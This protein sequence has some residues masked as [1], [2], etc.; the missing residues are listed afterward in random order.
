MKLKRILAGVLTAAMVLTSAPVAGLCSL[1]VQA[2]KEVTYEEVSR[3]ILEKNAFANSEQN[4]VGYTNDGPASY[5]FNGNS[6]NWWHSRYQSWNSLGDNE[7]VRSEEEKETVFVEGGKTVYVGS[8]FDEEILLGKITY[9][10]R[11]DNTNNWIGDFNL[12][13][14]DLSDP[15]ASPAEEDWRIVASS[16]A[17]EGRE[18]KTKFSAGSVQTVAL[19]TPV[20]ATHFRL[21]ALG[22]SDENKGDIHCVAATQICVFKAIAEEDTRTP[23]A[24]PDL[25]VTAPVE[26]AAPADVTV[27]SQEPGFTAVTAWTDAEGSAAAGSFEGGKT[28]TV[29][30]VLTADE[31][32]KFTADSIPSEITVDGEKAALSVENVTLSEDGTTM[33]IVCTLQAKEVGTEVPEALQEA[34]AKAAAIEENGKTYSAASKK[35]L[36]EA[37]AAAKAL[38]A[39]A[40]AEEL[41]SA[42]DAVLAAIENLAESWIAEEVYDGT[43]AI[44]ADSEEMT[45]ETPPNGPIGNAADG[46][47]DTFWHSNYNNDAA[48]KVGVEDGTLVSNNNAYLALPEATT[49]YGVNYVPRI[50][51]DG[52]M[53]AN[54]AITEANIYVS[55]DGGTTY[56]KVLSGVTWDYTG[57]NYNT[58]GAKEA[59]FEQ[60][61]EGVT[62][63]KIE[64]VHSAGQVPNKYINAAEFY[65]MVQEEKSDEREKLA[66][67]NLSITAPE[68]GKAPAD[69]TGDSY[70]PAVISDTAGTEELAAADLTVNAQV[71]TDGEIQ[72]I[73]GTVVADQ[74]KAANGKFNVTGETPFLIRL[75]MKIDTSRMN[76]TGDYAVIGKADHQYGVQVTK[77]SDGKY[78]MT[79]YA[80]ATDNSWPEQKIELTE[81]NLNVWQ[82]VVAMYN[83]GKFTI[84]AEGEQNSLSNRDNEGKKLGEYASESF[85]IGKNIGKSS[86]KEF[87]G[88]LAD[89]VMYT[90]DQVPT[91]DNYDE[92]IAALADKTPMFVLNAV[93]ASGAEPNYD[94]VS[95]VWTDAEGNEVTEFEAARDYTATVTLKAKEGYKFTDPASIPVVEGVAAKAVI[96]DDAKAGT[97]IMTVTFTFGADPKDK[98]VLALAEK[99]AEAKAMNNDNGTYTAESWEELQKAITAAEA[100]DTTEMTA[101]EVAAETAKL[102]AAIDGLVKV[103][104]AIELGA[105]TVAFT[106]PVAG[107]YPAPAAV[108]NG[109]GSAH[110]ETIADHAANPV[111]LSKIDA[112]SVQAIVNQDGVWGFMDLLKSGSAHDKFD[113]YGETPLMISFKL[114]VKEAVTGNSNILGKTN[115]QYG[116]QIESTRLILYCQSGGGW[117]EQTITLDSDFYGKWH[118]VVIVFDGKGQMG[119]YVDGEVSAAT[120]GRPTSA[121][122]ESNDNPFSMGYNFGA[123]N[124]NDTFTPDEGYLADVKLYNTDM[125]ESLT[126]DYQVIRNLLDAAEPLAN[127]T[128][129]PYDAKTTWAATGKD[130]LDA[131]AAFGEA[132]AYTATTVLTA[133][134]GYV[135]GDVADDI[136]QAAEAAS[137]GA[138]VTAVRSEDGKTMTVTAS[139]EATSELACSCEVDLT[140]PASET[141]EI[142]EKY[143]A[144]T[145]QLTASAAAKGDCK[146][147][148]HPNTPE[149]TYAVTKGSDVV[150][151]DGRGVLTTKTVG[152][153]EI[154]VTARLAKKEGEAPAEASKVIKVTVVSTRAE[155]SL[156]SSLSALI[157]TRE[158]EIKGELETDFTPDSVAE[159]KKAIE[160]AKAAVGKAP[161]VSAEEIRAALNNLKNVK[162]VSQKEKKEKYAELGRLIDEANAKISE[163]NESFIYVYET[164]KALGEAN[165]AAVELHKK[166]LKGATLEE[167]TAACE[168][169]QKALD[170]LVTKAEQE[171]ID[172]KA[173]EEAMKPVM[174]AAKKVADAGQANY[175]DASWKVFKAAYDAAEA[176]RKDAKTTAAKLKTLTTALQNA[177]KA[178]V[179]KPG[180]PVNPTPQPGDPV[181]DPKSGRYVIKSVSKKTVK[182]VQANKKNKNK[183]SIAVPA[184]IKINGEKYKVTEVSTNAFKGFTKLKKIVLTQNITTVG[185]NAFAGCKKLSSVVIKGTALKSIKAGAFKKTAKKITVSF[186]SKKVSAK[187]RAALLKKMKKAG[188]SKSAK[189]K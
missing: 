130:A 50:D 175:T 67:P 52:N 36:D 143:T 65:V 8:A 137:E 142:D 121:V 132:T 117:P 157:E 187:K 96:T 126:N 127:I 122:V 112:A 5:A 181:E 9:Q 85:A 131:K 93:P 113:I 62:N 165:V 154:T 89:V 37:V 63:I 124:K 161:A 141:I 170:S 111:E 160:D 68:A 164:V 134:D 48:P 51:E 183:A 159:L 42:A 61:I 28:Y 158:G 182:L 128:V 29:T 140:V 16:V 13:V 150:S 125:T 40:S 162:L 149:I 18:L 58:N 56:E 91:A 34:L 103:V 138:A 151:V 31:G 180:T 66:A 49:V 185:K 44:S 139:Y 24:A 92:L 179:E 54:G 72:A 104:S 114:F 69:V 78:Y 153:A 76:Q 106:A 94:I 4:P 118:D 105:P 1:T 43:V 38:G 110:H 53:K 144:M 74:S 25:G 129:A 17:G 156:V 57:W 83:G 166:G 168:E 64:A 189:L 145:K 108:T 59:P 163:N 147:E 22:V 77:S 19:D 116:F 186:K 120:A 3:E 167:L 171:A 184:T 152:E 15:S 39:D 174:E 73:D 27:N 169:L 21:E 30:A 7:V 136:K 135:F 2:A 81:D 146:V 47:V 178:L 133:H 46:N 70:V 123:D 177:Q 100:A 82:D 11:S 60:V 45:G 119:F 79:I 176:G 107:E 71:V 35:A 109:E 98:A 148:G 101:E 23:I 88:L 14:A 97:S 172:R 55:K 84:Y 41:Q 155:E 86:V 173:A 10:G 75:K 6:E 12:W 80:N 90:G 99:L 20:K 87:P 33:T 115:T 32:R 26:G 102:A 95:T 188:M